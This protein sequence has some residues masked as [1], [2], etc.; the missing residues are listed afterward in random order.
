MVPRG[1]VLSEPA[2]QQRLHVTGHFSDG[3]SR[4]L[5]CLSIYNCGDPALEVRE[6]GWVTAY[7]H[8]SRTEVKIRD[9]VVQ[10]AEIGAV[11]SSGGV[12]QPQLHFEV[13][14]AP[15]AKDKPRTIDPMLVLP[16]G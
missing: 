6:D 8:L 7:A 15:S 9:H 14:Y 1:V 13:R 4:D 2:R 16:Q 11:G 10:G 12:D 3:G 5:S